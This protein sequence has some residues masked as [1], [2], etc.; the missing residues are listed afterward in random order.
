MSYPG[1]DPSDAILAEPAGAQAVSEGNPLISQEYKEAV[2]LSG[3]GREIDMEVVAKQAAAQQVKEMF[4]VCDAWK[5]RDVVEFVIEFDSGQQ[6]LVRHMTTM[7]LINASLVEDIDFFTKKLFMTQEPVTSDA[8]RAE[9]GSSNF[10]KVLSD[11]EKR[12]RFMDMTG[13]LMEMSS[14]K[15][16][17]VHDFVATVELKS[18]EKKTVFGNE[19][20]SMAEQIELFGK[21][22]PELAEGETYSSAIDIG[23]RLAWFQELQKP[24]ELIKPFREQQDALLGSVQ[25]SESVDLPSV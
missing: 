21:P 13:R 22:I 24:L 1:V 5:P 7:D 18:G 6:A 16:K 11:P 3:N 25:P 19:I 23:D 8:E 9:A 12:H 14:V 2:T 4:S 15:P 10:W 17:V 20:K